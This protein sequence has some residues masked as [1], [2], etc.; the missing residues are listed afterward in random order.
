[1]F[2]TERMRTLAVIFACVTIYGFTS[3]LIRP[4]LA[5]ILESRGID[6]TIIGLNAAM[7]A[8]GMMIISPLIPRLIKS[9]GIKRFLISC[10]I[11]DVSM[12]LCYPLLDYLY[13]WFAI[14]LIAG[15]AA[16]ALLVASETWI[17]ELAVDATR[18]RV[19]GTYN[20]ML[21]GAIAMGPL[22]IPITGIQGWTPFL[23]GA[24]FIVMAAIP[25]MWV[26]PSTL[27]LHGK[28]SFTFFSFVLIA[29]TLTLAVILFAW[30]E[31]AGGSLLPVYGVSNGMDEST[32]A[33]MLTVL[34]I[35][36]VVLTFPFGWLADKMD[37]Y[38]LMIL[39]G[40]G[41]LVG[42]L[43]LPMVINGGVTLWI[44]L[45]CWGGVFAGLYTVI[46]TIVGQQFRGLE[47]AVA[48]IAIGIIWG[49]GSLT[50]PSLT[51]V[52]MDVWEPH[53]FAI[54]FIAASA[55]FVLFAMGRWILAKDKTRV[56]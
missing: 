37:R 17:N 10:L 52:A 22:I 45:F 33:I 21:I 6:R 4:L 49:I 27:T 41:I 35:G 14:S 31:Y 15:A 9:L 47:L 53:G 13:A 23:V 56:L 48:N 39:C 40:V 20:A 30:K 3:G 12:V 46:L 34:G 36:G 50:G 16:N 28:S 24:V 26:G 8:F 32:A 5:L 44:L 19:V 11:V 2:A 38:L 29:P 1:M 54:V 51:G 25:L 7:P 43:L 18:G 55:A 42:A